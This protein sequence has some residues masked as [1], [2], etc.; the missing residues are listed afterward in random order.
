M[1]F[2]HVPNN[3]LHTIDFSLPP[4]ASYNRLTL[5]GS[6]HAHPK[7]YI[8]CG[9]WGMREWKGTLFP[10]EI[11]EKD[12]PQYY[13]QHFNCIELNA[14]LYRLYPKQSFEQWAALAG[15]RPFKY[16]A[17]LP[18]QIIDALQHKAED[19]T[20]SF[21]NA[22]TGLGTH[23]G[24]CFLQLGEF[25]TADLAPS[26]K[27]YIKNFPAGIS[28]FIEL[29]HAS[30][31]AHNVQSSFFPFL[32]QTGT[33][34]IITDTPGRRDALHMCVTVPKTLIRFVGSRL[35]QLDYRRL[36]EWKH[37]LHS[38]FENGLEEAYMIMHAET[39]SPELA[40]WL[41]QTMQQYYM[42]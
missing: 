8:G 27:D 33:G 34:L 29:R 6:P 20:G 42:H 7:L 11:K 22:V 24:I 2:G 21:S 35:Q 37:R 4:D 10:A 12:F 41:R 9:R 36:T 1:R 15:N 16:C 28:L 18:S 14:T 39:Y 30:W 26:L 40:S 17:K 3:Q 31:F 13:I 5:K 38:W 23:L 19:V 25:T 32:Q